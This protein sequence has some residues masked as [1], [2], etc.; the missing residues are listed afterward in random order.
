VRRNR[1]WQRQVSRHARAQLGAIPHYRKDAV[2]HFDVALQ[3]DPYNTSACFQ[4]GELHEVMGLPWRAVALY[5]RILEVDPQHAKAI[6]KLAALE[7]KKPAEKSLFS[8]FFKR[9]K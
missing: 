7:T 9:D 6:A 4:C 1:T 8:R 5:K 2:H 3:L